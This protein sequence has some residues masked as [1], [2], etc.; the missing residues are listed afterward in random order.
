[1]QG[2]TCCSG[3]FPGFETEENYS[4]EIGGDIEADD[5]TQPKAIFTQGGVDHGWTQVRIDPTDPD[6]LS[7]QADPWKVD[8]ERPPKPDGM[9]AA[10]PVA[11]L[12]KSDK[13][14]TRSSTG[15][16]PDAVAGPPFIPAIDPRPR[17]SGK[18]STLPVE[19]DRLAHLPLCPMLGCS[20]AFLKKFAESEGFAA[21]IQ[22]DGP[23][24]LSSKRGS[25]TLRAE[26]KRWAEG[27]KSKLSPGRGRDDAAVA[28]PELQHSASMNGESVLNMGTVCNSIIKPRT[29]VRRIGLRSAPKKSQ[30]SSSRAGPDVTKQEE[31][32]Y[33]ELGLRSE[34]VDSTGKPAFGK[35]THFVSHAWKCSFRNFVEALGFWMQQSGTPEATTYF[36]VDAFVVNQHQ[37]QEFPQEW[38][39]TRFMQAI[40]EI[41][42]TV[43]IVE[44]WHHPVPLER[45]W[46]IWELYC[47][48]QQN[49][50]L[51][52]AMS[53]NTL[54]EFKGALLDSFE[55]VQT[56]M[57]YVDV[58]KSSAFHE[59]DRQMIHAEI[60]RT[61][62]FTKMNE[63]VQTR[64]TQWLVEYVKGQLYEFKLP[65]LSIYGGRQGQVEEM[66]SISSQSHIDRAAHFR[67]KENLARL[68]RESGRAEDAEDML[69]QLLSEVEATYGKDHMMSMSCLNQLAVTVQKLGKQ[70]EG[71][72]RHRDCYERRMRTLGSGHEDTLQSTSNLAVLMSGS[73]ELSVEQF[74]EARRLYS[75][76]I[77]GREASVGS[78][79]PRTLYTVSNLGT[80]LS[81]APVLSVEILKE[82][83]AFHDRAVNGLIAALHE[84]HPLTLTAMHHQACH[85]LA[86]CAFRGKELKQIG[87]SAL[88][89]E[90]I[91]RLQETAFEQLLRVKTLR[92][93]KLGKDHPDTALTEQVLAS[94]TSQ[95]KQEV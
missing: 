64:L 18:E 19:S 10:T 4:L 84:A 26:L 46:V 69:L 17:L 67:L 35:A 29:D 66:Q 93:E 72:E 55:R 76:A 73:R 78:T 36:W 49:S 59:H 1:M 9:P 39:S 43:L 88:N 44:P 30:A 81:K 91:E 63:L 90:E 75:L 79:H 51:H 37:T 14:A 28:A 45:A 68:L 20:H 65:R 11:T 47:T 70:Q 94:A 48:T 22:F 6:G 80:L 89:F 33:A 60:Q 15:P 8:E 61:I 38:W 77:S 32:S 92:T 86:Y 87:A 25:S 7:A 23:G 56:A 2:F 3:P 85:W 95:R 5:G 12:L 40:G 27:I 83:E 53:R 52:L 58:S 21:E 31:L 74:E 34:M 62:G 42:N 41:G 54:E 57:S 50:Q 13:A 24:G 71:L 82:G 16:P